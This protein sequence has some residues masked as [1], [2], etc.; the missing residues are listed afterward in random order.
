MV[1]YFSPVRRQVWKDSKLRNRPKV[2]INYGN[3]HTYDIKN[4]TYSLC[5]RLALKIINDTFTVRKYYPRRRKTK[6]IFFGELEIPYEY[7]ASKCET[8]FQINAS[9]I[10]A[11][12]YA[13]VSYVAPHHRVQ[14]EIDARSRIS[15][16]LVRHTIWS[17]ALARK[18]SPQRHRFI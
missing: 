13:N 16:A 6:I 7:T 11:K 5:L 17:H 14:S 3:L 1:T 8:F 18:P 12:Y 15:N 4:L 10:E 9:Y 2:A